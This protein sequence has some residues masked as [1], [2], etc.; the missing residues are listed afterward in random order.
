LGKD[1][2]VIRP[3]KDAEKRVAGRIDLDDNRAVIRYSDTG[4]TGAYRLFAGP[5]DLPLAAFAVQLAPSESD[6]RQAGR[7][8]IEA[9]AQAATA[10]ATTQSATAAAAPRFQV[11]REFWTWLVCLAALVALAEAALAHRLSQPR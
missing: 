3:G 5:G 9:L 8:E 6:L 1:F 11:S 10:P 7:P 2:S 4:T